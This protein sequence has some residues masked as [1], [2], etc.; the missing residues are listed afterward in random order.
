MEAKRVER[1]KGEGFEQVIDSLLRINYTSHRTISLFVHVHTMR[2]D[3]H[4]DAERRYNI[5]NIQP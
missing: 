2:G 5:T 3:S 1:G 4:E